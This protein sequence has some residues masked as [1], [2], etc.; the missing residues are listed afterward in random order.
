MQARKSPRKSPP[1]KASPRKSP[2]KLPNFRMAL[3][4]QQWAEYAK[5]S[6]G[7]TIDDVLKLKKGEQLKVLLLHRNVWDP[8]YEN[9]NLCKIF[10]PKVLFANEWGILIH[11]RDLQEEIFIQ[12]FELE[13]PWGKHIKNINKLTKKDIEIYKREYYNH[14]GSKNRP[15]EFD[16]EYQKG[17]WFPLTNGML[18]AKDPQGFANFRFQKPKSWKEFPKTTHVGY[19]GPMIKWDDLDKLPN[20]IMTLDDE[21]QQVCHK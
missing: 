21:Y 18:P 19:R 10:D 17:N 3:A 12:A 15:F 9:K 4:H 7:L 16:I 14:Y 2:R 11:D 6:Y 5:L 1:R 13:L 20:I 8:I